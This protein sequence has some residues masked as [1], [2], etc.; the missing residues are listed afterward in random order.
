[1]KKKRLK[2]NV[3]HNV[4]RCYY[5]NFDTKISLR[6][7]QKTNTCLKL[8]PFKRIF[9]IV[10]NIVCPIPFHIE[11]TV[12]SHITKHIINNNNELQLD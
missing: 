9:L 3:L 8:W 10:Q 6:I 4:Q 1:M 7:F 2:K 11:L 12:K 5:S